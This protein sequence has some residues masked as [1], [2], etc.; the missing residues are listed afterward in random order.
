MTK[1]K[2][3]KLDLVE[4]T[5]QATKN[6]DVLLDENDLSIFKSL[7]PEL[8]DSWTKKQIFRTE[9]EAEF[10][11]LNDAMHPTPAAKY[12]QCV[13]EQDTYFKQLMGLSFQ[14]RDNDLY[15][16]QLKENIQ[17]EKDRIK[18]ARYQI[19]LEKRL[20]DKSNFELEA[21]DRIRELKM[22]SNLKKKYDNN[23][24]DKENVNTHQAHSYRLEFENR[25]KAL[26]PES[27][28]IDK[29]HTLGQLSTIERML[30]EN[31]ELENPKRKVSNLIE[32]KKKK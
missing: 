31:P 6:I 18:K 23:S 28:F 19:R 5:K 27:P 29:M 13:R 32:K 30:K 24:F 10:S 3:K 17:K 20:F 8:K 9:T 1:N 4:T 26:N 25:R 2:N 7:I 14:Y 22:W 16:E 11:V 12:W 21:K 15:I